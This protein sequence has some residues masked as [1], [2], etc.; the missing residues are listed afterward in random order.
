MKSFLQS[1]ADYIRA[2]QQHRVETYLRGNT[3]E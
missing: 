3:W 2:Y 1:V